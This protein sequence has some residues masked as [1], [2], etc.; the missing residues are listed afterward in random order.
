[1]IR[2]TNECTTVT[3]AIAM[4]VVPSCLGEPVTPPG[5]S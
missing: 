1:M 5:N 2:V 3:K 4:I